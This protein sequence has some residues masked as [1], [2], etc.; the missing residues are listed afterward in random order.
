MLNAPTAR[1]LLPG[2]E[3][4]ST[5]LRNLAYRPRKSTNYLVDK[6]ENL[7]S[8]NG[9]VEPQP[10][11]ALHTQT[12]GPFH[13]EPRKRRMVSMNFATEIGFDR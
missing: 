5:A 2:Q 3:S 13:A 7:V 12:A 6:Q 10:P 9:P 1:G 4:L 11:A 8:L